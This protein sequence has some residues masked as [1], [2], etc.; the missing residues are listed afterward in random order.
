VL[1]LA[2]V[3]AAAQ[4]IVGAT[5]VSTPSGS[6]IQLVSIGVGNGA[7]A[8][9]GAGATDAASFTPITAYDPT[10]NFYYFLAGSTGPLYRVSTATGAFSSGALSG[11]AFDGVHDIEFDAGEGVLYALLRVNTDQMRLAT[12]DFG[13]SLGAITLLG[14][15][16]F[17]G[18]A[19]Q[20]YSFSVLDPTANRFYFVGGTT[21]KA[22]ST[23]TADVV[24]T[25]TTASNL[26]GIEADSDSGALYANQ[27]TGSPNFD[28]RILAL[29]TANDAGFGSVLST[30]SGLAGGSLSTAGWETYDS[31]G[32]RYFLIG[33]P[34]SG[35]NTLYAVN[36]P[37]LTLNDSDALAGVTT[38]PMAL[39]FD[40][41]PLAVALQSFDVE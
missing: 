5:F 6:R 39:E 12:I 17:Q 8:L 36:T 35:S 33:Q 28:R 7:V 3:P 30:G 25:G 18:G 2:S 10:G 26:A 13:G 9:I 14:T 21:L 37:A 19:V 29:S 1:L 11:A 40:P 41:G 34:A 38:D 27:G 15:G 24:N 31:P 4:Q 32:D 23:A 22:A 16:A 20:T